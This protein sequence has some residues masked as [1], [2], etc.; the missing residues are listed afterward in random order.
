MKS[1][2]YMGSIILKIIF[3]GFVSLLIFEASM[4]LVAQTALGKVLPVV[5]PQIGRPDSDTG[6]AFV[7]G[8][9]ALWTRENRASI[10]INQDG[11]IDRPI[12]HDNPPQFRIA[13]SGDSVAEA[14]QVEQERR[15][16]NL[17]EDQLFRSG[18]D[19]EVLNFA[20]AGSGPLRQLVRLEKKAASL[21]PDISIMLMAASD[22]QSGELHDDS[23]NPGYKLD[24][25]GNVVRS[26]SFRDRFSQ[27]YA[28]TTLGEVFLFLVRYS[29]TF[30]MIY[31]K[32]HESIEE[33]LTALKDKPLAIED[34]AP[35]DQCKSDTLLSLENFWLSHQPK[36]DWEIARQFLKEVHEYALGKP[37]VIGL[38]IPITPDAC[39]LEVERR[40][41]II[42]SIKGVMASEGIIFIDWNDRLRQASARGFP[43]CQP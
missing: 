27:R 43:G 15:F 2:K 13:L 35:E 9:K 12:R 36:E 28:E 22:F 21:S 40:K 19:V 26:Y 25:Q 24:V 4:A 20:M 38:Y 11:L 29:T 10:E 3:G 30:R 17:A 31:Y 1:F 23:Q 41:R 16:D 6:Y 18:Y 32:R 14:M 42:L 34:K 39:L 7:P 37:V 8:A 33:I 5:E